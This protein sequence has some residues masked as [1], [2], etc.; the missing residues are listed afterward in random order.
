MSRRRRANGEGSV[1]RR[2]SG[3]GGWEARLTYIDPVTG[4]RRRES[5]YG[6]TQAA[7][8]AKMAAARARV[9]SG[10]P[11]RD[12]TRTVGDWIGVWC[13]TTLAVSHRAPSTRALYATLA[14]KH[15][16]PA[17]FG[18]TSLDRLRPSDVERLI[19]VLR[20]RGL[21]DSTVRQIYTVARL[22]L[23]TAVRDG[24][25]VR[26]PAA[27]VARPGV[28]RT[29]ARHLDNET[30]TALL[31]A[32]KDSRY[33]P[34]LVLIAGTGLRRGEA[35]ALTWDHVDLDNGTLVIAATLGRIG[36]RLVISEPKTERSRRQ[37]PLSEVMVT[38][39]RRHRTAQKAERLKAGD[40]W[41]E[42]GLVFCTELGRPVEPRNLL[43]VI[44][45]AAAVAKLDGV[46]VHTLRHSA[47]VD[48]LET[49][50]HIKAVAD[51]LG[52]SSIAITGDV[53]GHT[54]HDVARAAID[55]RAG[56]LRL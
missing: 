52:H 38:L 11:V 4:E 48:W 44:E 24:L 25:L 30:L 49:G 50:T 5:F 41:H 40:Q 28:A 20:E 13:E 17:P 55:G 9:D 21:A 54:T 31:D 2:R 27:A 56:R 36:K 3:S 46:G 8:R 19:A 26:N 7:V 51:L 35:L 23:D 6:P 10:A 29:E 12:S 43:R 39:L 14:T 47:A 34:V 45:T 22:A 1:R 32:A 18:A 53:Y 16:L 15:L 37:V 33:H 42:H